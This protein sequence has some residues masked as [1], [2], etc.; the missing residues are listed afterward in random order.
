[1][2]AQMGSAMHGTLQQQLCSSVLP[3][4]AASVTPKEAPPRDGEAEDDSAAPGGNS[5]PKPSAFIRER[6]RAV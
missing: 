2:Q 5:R 6:G 4:A 3:A 1:M